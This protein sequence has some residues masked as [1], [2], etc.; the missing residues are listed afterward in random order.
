[1]RIR[2][3]LVASIMLRTAVPPAE[4]RERAS[5]VTR[6]CDI[7]AWIRNADPQGMAVRAAPPAESPIRAWPPGTVVAAAASSDKWMPW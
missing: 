5:P 2:E 7:P 3:V 4:S 1:M 6:A